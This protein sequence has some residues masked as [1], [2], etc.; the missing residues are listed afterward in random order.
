M[1]MTL[2]KGRIERLE[3]V[4]RFKEWLSIQWIFDTCSAP[5]PL[6]LLTA[7]DVKKTSAC[8]T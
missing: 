5:A 3:K 8:R 4:M 6:P 7:C 2:L 1:T